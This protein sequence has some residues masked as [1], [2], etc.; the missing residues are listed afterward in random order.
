M[1]VVSHTTVVA[2]GSG[3]RR[4]RVAVAI[5]GVVLGGRH[6]ASAAAPDFQ[7]E[8]QP[9][10]AEHC[11]HCHGVDEATRQGGLR[12][13]LRAAAL[14]G[15][16]SGQAAIVPGAVEAS[17]MVAR[18]R[19]TD[20]DVVMPPPREQKPLSPAEVR[21]VEEWIA[22]GAGYEPPWAFVAP[23]REAVPDSSAGAAPIDAFVRSHLAEHG[24]APT[25]PAD[26]A[27]LCRRLHLT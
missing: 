3:H 18:I 21:L 20:P 6:G 15:G 12:L 10:L 8:I 17:E 27:T 4:W 2:S 19:S 5:A 25:P 16:D 23:R 14:T 26:A 7:R 9:I 11:A 24:L 1:T 13:D 22:A